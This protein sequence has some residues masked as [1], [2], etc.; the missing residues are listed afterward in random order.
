M[1][2][3]HSTQTSLI[4]IGG[5]VEVGRVLAR[6]WRLSV[7]FFVASVSLTLL[8][9]WVARHVPVRKQAVHTPRSRECFA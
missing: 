4:N 7:G 8:A 3:S 9:L 6:H 2:T 5:L 1:K